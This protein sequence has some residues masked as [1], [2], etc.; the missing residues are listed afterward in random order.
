MPVSDR[1]CLSNRKMELTV[2]AGMTAGQSLLGAKVAMDIESAESVHALEFFEAIEWHLART[3]HELEQ[4]GCLFLVEA[5]HCTPEPLNLWGCLS[6]VVVVCV[7]LPVVNVD[8]WQTR[9]EQLEFLFREDGDEFRGNNLLEA[10]SWLANSHVYAEEMITYLS[11]NAPA[12]PR[13]T[14]SIFAQLPG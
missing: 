9:D 5:A 3:R 6:V 4:L 8:V 7:A 13:Q 14:W 12:A 2:E 1:S 11:R 10:C